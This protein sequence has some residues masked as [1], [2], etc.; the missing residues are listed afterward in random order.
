ME[1]P[2]RVRSFGGYNTLPQPTLPGRS[3]HEPQR[4]LKEA[5]RVAIRESETCEARLEHD[6]I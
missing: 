5:G 3:P 1:H 2:D 4:A 6:P